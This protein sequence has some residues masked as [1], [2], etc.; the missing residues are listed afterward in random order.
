[1][2]GTSVLTWQQYETLLEP[3]TKELTDAARWISETGQRLIVVFEGRDTAGKGG[4]ID[5]FARTLNPRQCH[6]A[7]LPA[8]STREQGQWYFQRYAQHF[9]SKGEITLF[10]RSWYNRAGVEKVMGYCSPQQAEAFLERRPGGERVE[11]RA[12]RDLLPPYFGHLSEPE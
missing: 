3:L 4:S 12:E 10:D 5:M 6:I 1:M 7:A 9:P 2:S 11:A 8:P